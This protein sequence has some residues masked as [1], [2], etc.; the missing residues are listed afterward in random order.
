MRESAALL[1]PELAGLR[2]SLH[3]EP[4][5]GLDLPLTRA[6]VLAALDGLP[7]EITLGKQLSS[8]TAV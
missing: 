2:R 7:L 8:V 1:Q 5:I 4:E 6:K 3:Q